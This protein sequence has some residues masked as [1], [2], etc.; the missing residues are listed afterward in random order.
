MKVDQVE[1]RRLHSQILSPHALSTAARTLR[2]LLHSTRQAL[3]RPVACA[4]DDP[5]PKT[6]SSAASPPNSR[7]PAPR[8]RATDRW[9]RLRE[10]RAMVAVRIPRTSALCSVPVSRTN[11]KLSIDRGT[12]QPPCQRTRF[13]RAPVP[14]PR[15]PA[16]PSPA[17]RSHS[18]TRCAELWRLLRAQTPCH[19]LE[20]EE[21]SQRTAHLAP[22]ACSWP[23]PPP[24]LTHLA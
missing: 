20:I 15:P 13:T 24:P 11:G 4:R 5:S 21:R 10:H 9:R 16:L 23:L 7:H 3:S 18:R 6:A 14:A 8:A 19:S 22:R 2:A 1:L 17:P 12:T